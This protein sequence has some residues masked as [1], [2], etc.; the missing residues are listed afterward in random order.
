MTK[1][2]VSVF[3]SVFACFC[4]CYEELQ[5]NA[6]TILCQVTGIIRRVWDKWAL[7]DIGC[8]RLARVHAREHP[9]ERNEC[10]GQSAQGT[11]SLVHRCASVVKT[12]KCSKPVI[13]CRY[14]F[15]IST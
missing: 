14:L 2:I 11:D 5:S 3:V 12:V 13:Q 9:R 15:E 4:S 1:N 10:L 6:P 7:V 8:D